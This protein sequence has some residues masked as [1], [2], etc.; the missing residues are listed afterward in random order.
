MTSIWSFVMQTIEVS[1]MAMILLIVKKV[2]KDKLS[3]RWQYGI[4]SLL[5]ICMIVP[6]GVFGTYIFPRIA[7]YIEAIKSLVENH[8][9][10][11]YIQ[12]YQLIRN[13]SCFPYITAFPLSLTDF[14]FVIYILGVVIG[15]VRYMLQYIMLRHLLK[16]GYPPTYQQEQQLQSVCQEYHLKACQMVLIENLPSAFI[17]GLIKPILVLPY[18]QE[19]DDKVLLHE[20]LHY[21]YKDVL[22]NVIWSLFQCLHWCNPFMNYIFKIIHNDMESLC[23]Q[24]VL[25]LLKGEERREYGRILLSMTNEQYPHAFFTTSLSNGG[26]CIK[27]RIEAIVR[28][29]QYPKGMSLVSFCI[30]MML[31]PLAITGQSSASYIQS[32]ETDISNFSY[33]VSLASAR[34]MKCSTMAGAIDVYAKGILNNN[35]MYLV[36]VMPASQQECYQD[37]LK[38]KPEGIWADGTESL[39]QIVNLKEMDKDDYEAYLLFQYF[40]E[41]DE[42]NQRFVDYTLIPIRVFKENG[43]KLIQNGDV[44][45]DRDLLDN[46]SWFSG[47][48]DIFRMKQVSNQQTIQ[49]DLKRGSLQLDIYD[50]YTVKDEQTTRDMFGNSFFSMEANPNATIGNCCQYVKVV[51]QDDMSFDEPIQHIGLRIK[52]LNHI[53]DEIGFEAE[54]E[55]DVLNTSGGGSNGLEASEMINTSFIHDWNQTHQFQ[56]GYKTFSDY[57]YPHYPFPEGYAVRVLINGKVLEDVKIEVGE[58]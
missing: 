58:K 14:L 20:L 44:V 6:V 37:V 27:E 7:V 16:K 49:K 24:R 15:I 31:L 51:Y 53:T 5:L 47:C 11:S 46:D 8:L 25:E 54:N 39:Y 23:D 1:L 2:L 18:H 32:Y 3:P 4:W 36:S 26:K 21:Q 33:Q 22:Q 52:N 48:F 40:E 45:K 17:C 55:K 56:M 28:F 19:V 13:V 9:N 35:D 43:W 10:S 57:D 30:G 50:T 38:Q 41:F 29:K 42:I 34:M 12:S